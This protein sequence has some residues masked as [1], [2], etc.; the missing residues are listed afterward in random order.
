MALLLFTTLMKQNPSDTVSSVLSVSPLHCCIDRLYNTN[1][2]TVQ[3]YIIEEP[4]DGSEE[5]TECRTQIC[6]FEIVRLA[7]SDVIAPA[8]PI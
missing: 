8:Q 4:H 5:R 1:H 6:K 2:S 3:D 7:D